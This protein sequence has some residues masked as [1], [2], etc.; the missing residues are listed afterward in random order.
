MFAPPKSTN[1]EKEIQSDILPE[2]VDFAQQV[3]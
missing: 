2:A 3:E 1:V